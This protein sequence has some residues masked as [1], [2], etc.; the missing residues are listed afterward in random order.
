MCGGTNLKNTMK[1]N[2]ELKRTHKIIIQ[3]QK[4][5]KMK[6][7]KNKFLW[8]ENNLLA[9]FKKGII[10]GEIRIVRMMNLFIYNT[11]YKE[12]TQCSIIN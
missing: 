10:Y 9:V 3:K 7:H 12:R 2:F 8:F 6:Q 1:F 5:K 11:K 4:K